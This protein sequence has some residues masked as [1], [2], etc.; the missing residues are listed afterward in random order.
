MAGW[1]N[2]IDIVNKRMPS[3]GANID[4]SVDFRMIPTYFPADLVMA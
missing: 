4:Q 3:I 2:H 1:L